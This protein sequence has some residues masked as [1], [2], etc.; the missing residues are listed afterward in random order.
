M[1]FF[2]NF[3]TCNKLIYK[4]ILRHRFYRNLTFLQ[5]VPGFPLQKACREPM[6]MDWNPAYLLSSF[7]QFRLET[8]SGSLT[9]SR[10]ILAF[11]L[12]MDVSTR[13]PG[14]RSESILVI[15]DAGRTDHTCIDSSIAKLN[16]G[17]NICRNSNSMKIYYNRS[18]SK[19]SG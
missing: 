10:R 18:N 13:C 19:D 14:Y 9:A 7:F 11:E 8:H 6:K 3:E 1:R 15:I 4:E 17:I 5:P 16:P 2:L 12:C